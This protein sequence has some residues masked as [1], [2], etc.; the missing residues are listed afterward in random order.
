[1]KKEATFSTNDIIAIFRRKK[2]RPK[3]RV[4]RLDKDTV[5]IEGTSA[6]FE[7][8]GRFLL[9]H[10]KEKDC[11]RWISPKGPGNSWFTKDSKLGLYL[12]RLPCTRE[13]PCRW[14]D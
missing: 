2:N 3:L 12:H 8:L 6:A 5:L 11:T 9:A 10:S 4:K 14:R 13:R 7:F 1:M